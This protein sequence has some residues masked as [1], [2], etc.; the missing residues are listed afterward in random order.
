MKINVKKARWVSVILIILGI[1]GFILGV[2]LSTV[3]FLV[4]LDIHAHLLSQVFV[5]SGCLAIIAGLVLYCVE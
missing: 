2:V 1:I 4:I 5:L 3:H